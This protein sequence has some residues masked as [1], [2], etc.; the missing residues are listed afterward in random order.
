[1]C[2]GFGFVGMIVD[3]VLVDIVLVGF[4]IILII[5]CRYEF[6][7]VCCC[8][9]LLIGVVFVF[10]LWLLVIV[11]FNGVIV[12][13]FGVKVV[14]YVVIGAG[15]LMLVDDDDWMGCFFDLLFVM[16]VLVDLVGIYD[17]VV[18]GVGCVDS[19]FGMYDFVVL[20]ILLLLMMF[21][22]LFVLYCWSCCS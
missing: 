20:V 15:V 16:T 17:Y 19:F 22:G 18:Y 13:V 3:I 5:V 10:C 1:L 7:A 8:Y 9:K 6:V 4:G 2:V 11:F 14:E 21:V 12:F